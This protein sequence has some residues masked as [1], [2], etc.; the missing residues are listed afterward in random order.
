MPSLPPAGLPVFRKTSD[1]RELEGKV[2][3]EWEEGLGRLT[4]LFALFRN[5]PRT[6]RNPQTGQAIDIPAK[7]VVKFNATPRFKQTLIPNP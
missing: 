7:A 5:R 1:I 3:R 6:G 2:R 4:W